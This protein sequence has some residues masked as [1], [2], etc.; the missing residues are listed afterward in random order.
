MNTMLRFKRLLAGL[1][2]LACCILSASA[3][4]KVVL[5]GDSITELWA[6]YHP[7]FFTDNGIVCAGI[8]GQVSGQMLLRFRSDVIDRHPAVV[9]INGGTNDIA[10]NQGPYDEDATFGHIVAMV[11]LAQA[12]GIRPVLSSVLPAAGFRWRKSVTDA[13]DKIASL[14]ARLQAYALE[15]EIPYVN[16]YAAMVALGRVLNPDYTNDGVHPTPAGYDVMEPLL[17]KA[18]LPLL[19]GRGHLVQGTEEALMRGWIRTLGSDEFGGRM[20]MTEYETTTIRYLAG[21]MQEIGLEPAFG[22]SYFQPVQTIS[23]VCT[24][25]GETF[26]VQGAGKAADLRFPDDLVVWTSRATDRIDLPA[27]EFVFCGFGIDAPEFSWNDFDGID[28]KGKIVIAMVNDPGFY[29]ASLFQGRN[30]TYYGRWTY[31]FEQAQRMGAAGCLVLHNTAA[32]SYGWNVAANHTGSNLA[33]YDEATGNA[34][35]LLLKGWLHEEGCR[36]IFAAAGADFEAALAAARKP[37]FKAFALD[38]RCGIALDVHHEIQETCNVAGILPGTDLK[39]EA[40]VFSAHW[41][42]FGYG[43]PDENGDAIYNGAADN[44]S[45]MAAV[46]LLAKKYSELP[47]RPRRSML[48]LIPTLE[49]S[50]LFGSEYYCAHPAFPMDRTAACINF[51][52]I[53][54]EP[55]TYDVV[56]LG[57]GACE[58]DAYIQAC[59]GAQGRYVVFNDDNSDGWF[60]RSDHFNFVKKGVP[61]VVIEYGTDLVDPSRPNKYPRSDWYHKPSDEYREDWDFAGTLAHVNLMYAVGLSVAN[62]DRKPVRFQQ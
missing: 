16:Y 45:G 52:C 44:G 40:V 22:D 59:A 55:L 49:E 60:F 10:E 25:V 51:D 50:G 9:V 47:V 32:A 41:D 21:Q 28:V 5:M 34:G 19:P 39:E 31:K 24:P 56:V 37:G 29:D 2:L 43:T 46:L 58:L 18:V 8:S 23:T 30:M 36:K 33:L 42:H 12:N 62:A 1:T 26:R 7:G 15:N 35:E 6:K 20:P 4:P 48:F 3:Q 14:N 61:A 53:A 17:L 38:A 54:P 27:A 13:P 11:E 57:G